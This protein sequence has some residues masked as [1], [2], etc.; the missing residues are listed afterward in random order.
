MPVRP[1]TGI[2]A[3]R[4][5]TELTPDSSEDLRRTVRPGP[6]RHVAPGHSRGHPGKGCTVKK[7]D[8]HPSPTRPFR[9]QKSGFSREGCTRRPTPAVGVQHLQRRSTRAVTES[10]GEKLPSSRFTA[11]S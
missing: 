7:S 11:A 10:L 5:P 2:R 1:A 3:L 8:A 9:C 4:N 6:D